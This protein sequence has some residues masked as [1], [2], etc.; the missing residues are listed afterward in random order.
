MAATPPRLLFYARPE[1]HA[2]R[3][4]YELGHLALSQL[5]AEGGLPEEWELYGIGS[6]ESGSIELSHGRGLRLIARQSQDEYAKVLRSCSAGLSLMLTPHPS[7]PPLE[8]ASAGMLTVTNSF[9][10]KTAEKL[11]A[12]SPNLIPAAPTIDGVTD[13][14]R[15]AVAGVGD[16][17]ARIRGADVAWARNWEGALP[18]PLLERLETL[19]RSQ[20]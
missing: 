13:G 9:E 4:M 14:L 16:Y 8:M 2:A 5:I 1:R 10:T 18:D 3:N 6:L 20:G 7:L 12:L 17:E 11:G 19:I 15:R